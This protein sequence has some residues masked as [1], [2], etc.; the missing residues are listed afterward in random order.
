MV[1]KRISL[2]TSPADDGNLWGCWIRDYQQLSRSDLF[3]LVPTTHQL[4]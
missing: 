4:R 1:S 3:Y 2:D